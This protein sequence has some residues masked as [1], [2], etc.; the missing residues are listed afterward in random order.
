M[1]RYIGKRIIL[2]IFTV[3]VLASATFFL[4]K[5]L[6]GNPFM[7]DKIPREIQ[8]RQ[9]AY[10]GLDKP[11]VVQYV[12]YLKNLL[13]G[14]FGSS[15]VYYGREVSSIIAEGFPASASLGITAVIFSQLI[16]WPAGIIAS[17]YKNKWPDYLLMFIAVLGIALPSMVIG[18]IVRYIFGVKL[19]LFPPTGWGS[20]ENYVLP[21]T[22][23][24]FESIGSGV[25]SMRGNMLNVSTE[26]YIK[27]ARAKGLSTAKVVL[28]HQ[29]RNA[30]VPV[31]TGLGFRIATIIM[32]SFVIESL[33]VIPGLGKHMVNALSTLDYPVVMG[34]TI[35]YGSFLVFIN[36]LVDIA[37]G[38]VDPRIRMVS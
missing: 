14:D 23:M 35:F 6:P 15:L 12:I 9:L 36:L 30:S 5:L 11:V 7:N 29:F 19:K 33:F 38:I 13:R 1:L 8:Q 18:P 17:L 3:F 2:S 16:S 32:G 20:W 27:T 34:L 24:M 37:Y 10:Y 31:I 26:D 4:S 25:R 21:V 22:V 28:R